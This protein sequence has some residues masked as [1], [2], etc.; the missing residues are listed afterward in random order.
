MVNIKKIE[1]QIVIAIDGPAGSGKGTIGRMLADYFHLPYL[2]SGRLYRKIAL[3][4]VRNKIDPHDKIEVIK[5]IKNIDFNNPHDD[6]ERG[7]N[8]SLTS[9]II[10]QYEEVR[11]ELVEYQRSFASNGG[12]VDGRDIGTIIFPNADFKFFITA[13]LD[14]RT[15]RRFIQYQSD[16]IKLEKNIIRKELKDRDERD[17]NRKIA[18]LFC[19]KDAIKIDT[20]TMKVDDVFDFIVKYIHKGM[21]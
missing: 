4:V 3:D 19:A 9:S 20:S 5:K 17:I 15:N 6:A 7:L 12:V 11:S 21:K 14:V 2:D 16:N 1:T 10:S 13:S 8:I 18:P